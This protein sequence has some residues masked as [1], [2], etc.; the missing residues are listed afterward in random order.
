MREART[1]PLLLFHPL[2]IAF[3]FAIEIDDGDRRNLFNTVVNPDCSENEAPCFDLREGNLLTLKLQC[4]L[5][6]GSFNSHSATLCIG[7]HSR[8]KSTKNIFFCAMLC[9]QKS[10]LTKT[11]NYIVLTQTE[12]VRKHFASFCDENIGKRVTKFRHS[13]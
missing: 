13:K 3:T 9:I 11:Y 7:I 12:T 2:M 4:T 5:W 6:R 1:F 8:D 10:L